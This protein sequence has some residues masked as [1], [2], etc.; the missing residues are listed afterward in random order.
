MTLSVCII[1]HNQKQFI[2]RCL[3]SIL[4]QKINFDYEILLSD[5]NS[6]DG[7]WEE[8]LE[9]KTKH[10]DLISCYRIN[11]NDYNPVSNSQRSGLNRFNIYKEAK[12]KYITFIDGDDY[13]LD[14][15]RYQQQIDLLEANPD[16]SIC[17]GNT[18]L[19]QEAESPVFMSLMMPEKRFKTGSKF[20]Q[21]QFFNMFFHNSTCIMKRQENI[22]SIFKPELLVD[23]QMTLFHLNFGNLIYIDKPFLSYIQQPKGIYTS[24]SQYRKYIGSITE[25][26]NLLLFFPQL[27]KQIKADF[28]NSIFYL[29]E[30]SET[31]EFSEEDKKKLNYV[32]DRLYKQIITLNNKNTLFKSRIKFLHF[33]QRALNKLKINKIFSIYPIVYSICKVKKQTF[34]YGA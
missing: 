10:P 31:G 30:T 4:S 25:T 8:L 11:T 29:L 12:G 16:C 3:D 34:K 18:A 14:E 26:A 7:T 2:K 27:K 6:T 23:F 32:S 13:V 9:W 19:Y 33:V 17:A 5:D 1:F 21:K 15:T 24:I 22:A 28:S 20:T